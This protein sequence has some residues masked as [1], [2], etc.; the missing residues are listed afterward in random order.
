MGTG[1]NVFF[2]FSDQDT[3]LIFAVLNYTLETQKIVHNMTM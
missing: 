1:I 2:E 3:D